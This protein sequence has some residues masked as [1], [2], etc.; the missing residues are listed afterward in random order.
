MDLN[1]LFV[2]LQ[3]SPMVQTILIWIALGL[4]VGVAAKIVIPGSENMG[5]IRTIIL[6]IGGAFLGH[7]IGANY[8]GIKSTS[9]FSIP[10]ILISIG[11]AV[12]LVLIN[13]IVT[14]T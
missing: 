2:S 1:S 11:G 9:F 10:G 7:F 13:R 8:L 4:I 5:W 12:I 6:G 14:R 3:N